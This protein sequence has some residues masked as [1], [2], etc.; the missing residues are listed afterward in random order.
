M[1]HWGSGSGVLVPAAGFE[2]QMHFWT[3]QEPPKSVLWHFALSILDFFLGY[4]PQCPYKLGSMIIVS[5]LIR[6]YHVN[7]TA[8]DVVCSVLYIVYD[9]I[10]VVSIARLLSFI[11]PIKRFSFCLRVTL[12]LSRALK[13]KA[14]IALPGNPISEL[15]D[16]T[17]HMGSHSDTCHPTQANAPRFN[18]SHAGWY[19]IYL[20]RKDGRLSWPSWLDSAPAGSRTSDLSITSPTPNRCTTKTTIIRQ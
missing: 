4:R 12:F 2:M 9:V 7:C 16:V 19:S 14:D 15:R 17:C 10:I 1:G 11:F 8:N 5:C 3:H 6:C 18:P 20:P 13:V